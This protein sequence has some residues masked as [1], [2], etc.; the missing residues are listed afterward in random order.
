MNCGPRPASVH[1]GLAMDGGTELIGARPSAAPVSMG[2]GQEAEEE[3][4]DA[5]N[6][7]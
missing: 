2:T 6:S 4:W 7:F 5:G 3:E 1:G